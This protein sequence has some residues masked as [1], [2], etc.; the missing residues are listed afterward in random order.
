MRQSNKIPPS[1]P[2]TVG[3]VDSRRALALVSRLKSS[4]VDLL[5]W[6][7]DA[8]AG[9]PATL[10]FPWILTVR[11]PAEGGL[12][13]LSSLQRRRLFLESLDQARFVDIELRSLG[14][15]RDVMSSARDRHV[16]II[17]SYHNFK[18]T[19][20]ARELR[21]TISRASDQGADIIKIATRTEAP[22]DIGRLLDLFA[23]SSTPLSL[24]GMGP[25]GM[26]SRLLFASCG[27]VL[28]YGWLD[29][30]NVEGQW[31]AVEL[32]TMITRTSSG[33]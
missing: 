6:R 12:G 28:N 11:H 23:A 20:P 10:R 18:R 8:F 30:P 27:S 21:D 14:P 4:S 33:R 31:S 19:P 17:A 5:E 22:A 26:T 9:T 3:I 16:R 32:K 15:M 25:L 13:S 29:R 24:M 2:L 1:T 7:A